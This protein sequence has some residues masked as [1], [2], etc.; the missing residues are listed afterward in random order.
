MDKI[1]ME[2]QKFGMT[3]EQNKELLSL[4]SE[5]VLHTIFKDFAEISSD[6]DLAVMETR[7]QQSKS[8]EHLQSI[9]NDIAATVYADSAQEEVEGIYM[10]LLDEFRN[11][12][13]KAKEILTKADQGDQKT[14]EVLNAAKDTDIYKELAASE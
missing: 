11:D 1:M 4:L 5:Q 2:I 3:E 14:Q 12:V 6:S 10:T 9:I 7:L 8:P 13:M